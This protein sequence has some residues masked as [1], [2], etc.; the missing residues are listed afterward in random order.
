M[1][2]A[3]PGRG[4]GPHFAPREPALLPPRH[5][6]RPLWLPHRG[7]RGSGRGRR[8]LGL[9]RAPGEVPD[10]LPVPRA[11][12]L[13]NGPVKPAVHAGKPGRAPAPPADDLLPRER[14]RRSLH[15]R[16]RRITGD[17]ARVWGLNL[18]ERRRGR[19]RRRRRR[20]GVGVLGGSH[21]VRR[22]VRADAR[23]WGGF[24][25]RSR[26]MKETDV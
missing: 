23:F 9:E 24:L 21:G 6:R 7:D 3:E 1:G 2:V 4:H 25:R 13:G 15:L 17:N 5:R 12:L 11:H 26:R 19:R 8:L 20:R 10:V 22:F 14:L 16:R 18:R